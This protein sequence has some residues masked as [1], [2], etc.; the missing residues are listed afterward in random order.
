MYLNSVSL[1][2]EAIQKRKERQCLV[3]RSLDGHIKE[4]F[5]ISSFSS[6]VRSHISRSMVGSPE[7]P[8]PLA[9]YGVLARQ[10]PG[11]CVEDIACYL[12]SRRLG[13]APL[14]LAFTR[15]AFHSS[16]ND[17]LFRVKVPFTSWSKKG[18]L[19][20]N[21]TSVVT[22]TNGYSFTDLNMVRMDT[23]KVVDR[24]LAEYHRIQQQEIFK[25]FEKPYIWGDVSRMWGEIL[26]Q[27]K[28]GVGNPRYVWRT[29]EDNKDVQCTR[30]Y[31]A[32]EARSLVV[33]PSSKW[34]YHLYLS[35]F[36]DGTF[37]LLDTYDNETGGVPE[38]RRLFEEEM[39][40]IKKATGFMPL[41]VKTY[42]L[43]QDMLYVNQH[44]IDDPVKAAGVLQQAK[45]WTDDT[46]SMTRWFAD[47]AIQ[48]G[49]S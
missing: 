22:N 17:K 13:L 24:S 18:N 20:V 6:L 31:T 30:E 32:E 46:V 23:F 1:A 37:V 4:K 44:I 40:A 27:A 11:A 47:Q 28:G 48:V 29:G 33:R 16:S 45:Y 34:Y 36:L 39:M 5:G 2:K 49:K 10:V 14:S 43:R 12:L 8:D 21:Y 15:D 42:P 9:S 38:A 19:Q 35:M 3:Q 25:H 7:E 26:A 41:V